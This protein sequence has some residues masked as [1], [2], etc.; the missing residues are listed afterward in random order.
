MLGQDKEFNILKENMNKIKK[1]FNLD[2]EILKA[3][4]SKEIKA[5]Q[6]YP[7]KPAILLS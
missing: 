6:A 5:K 4:S 3:E 2:I 1:E 7:S